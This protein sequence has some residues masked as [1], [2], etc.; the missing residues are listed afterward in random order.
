GR[1]F[2]IG[3]VELVGMRD[4]PPCGYL[5]RI[6]TPGVMTALQGRGGLRAEVVVSGRLSEGDAVEV[7]DGPA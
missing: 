2:R 7:L 1:R 5:Q 4:C 3:D 6:T